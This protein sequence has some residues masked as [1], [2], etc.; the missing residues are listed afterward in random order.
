M[1]ICVSW[2][3][4]TNSCLRHGSAARTQ[5]ARAQG[6]SAPVLIVPQEELVV[7]CDPRTADLLEVVSIVPPIRAR[8]RTS[9]NTP[10]VVYT[11]TSA[12]AGRVSAL[13]GACGA[14]RSPPSNIS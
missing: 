14:R 9:A 7:D 10:A 12:T 8:A 11:S 4:M 6:R 3:N 5:R 1:M 2:S 13:L